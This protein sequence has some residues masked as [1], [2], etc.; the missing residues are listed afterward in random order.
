MISFNGPR[1]EKDGTYYGTAGKKKRWSRSK[2]GLISVIIHEVGHNWFPMIINSDERQWT[3]MDEG[4][5]TFLQRVAEL[6]WEKDY[7]SWRGKPESIVGYMRST[8]TVPIMTN[9]ESL[10][11]V[12]SNAYAKPA[13]ALTVLRESIMGRKRFDHAFKLYAN[14]WRFKQPQPADFFRTME[15]ASGMD[16]DWFWR[17]W[18][19]TTGHVDL[20]IKTVRRFIMDVHNPT[21]DKP[22]QKAFRKSKE[23]PNISQ[24]RN[25]K[26]G[27]SYR[28]NRFSQLKDFY[29]NFDPDAVTG[30][31][32]EDFEKYLKGLEKWEQKLLEVKRYFYVVELEN[33]GLVMPVPLHITYRDGTTERVD[34]PAEIWAKRARSVSK[35][36]M[37]EKEII[38]L[39]IDPNKGLRMLI[40]ATTH[41]RPKSLITL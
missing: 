30:Q 29:N 18:F 37:R 14:R 32:K 8:D 25:E 5:N 28:V 22:A 4:L 6:E 39:E 40:I 41:G 24:T 12:G 38:S 26:E 33:K 10:L 27:R 19:Y 2:Y 23:A 15:D 7:P 34:Y 13:A 3:W 20:G 9:S 35:L 31:E 36:L 11:R 1:A 17:G 21:V 16:L